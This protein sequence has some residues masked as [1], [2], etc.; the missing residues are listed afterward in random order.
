MNFDSR[1][2]QKIKLYYQLI[3]APQTLL[4]L[5]TGVTG[6]LSARC[7]IYLITVFLGMVGSLFLVVSGSTILNMVYDRDIDNKMSRTQ[8]RPL[9]S[10]QLKAGE[11][12][13]VGLTISAAGLFWAWL[14]SPLYCLIVFAGLF[15]D[16]VV[17]TIWLKRFTGWSIIWGG[18]SGG[19]P[20][21]A[22]RAL[23]TGHVDMIGL[24]LSSAVLLWIPTHILTFAMRYYEDYKRA[25]I[26]TIVSTY[27]FQKSRVIIASS[28]ICAAIAIG[29]GITALGL[30]WGYIRTFMIM[31]LSLTGLAV[32]TI[33]HPNERLNMN[34]FKFASLFMLC[35][36]L[37][38]V[39][40]VLYIA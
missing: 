40:G 39:V 26:P 17:Y 22:G 10:G 5:V 4:L 15:I 34:L 32:Y 35:S 33:F 23:G 30:S 1:Q 18:I 13:I 21:L 6:Y 38:I 11:V 36:M 31:A 7:P 12:L 8:N 27:G 19:M 16:V 9:P 24:L 28:S 25:G 20:I 37:L 14:L 3:K 2:I 29:I